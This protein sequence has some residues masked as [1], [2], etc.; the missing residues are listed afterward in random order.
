MEE[1]GLSCTNENARSMLSYNNKKQSMIGEIKYVTLVLCAHPKIHTTLN[2]QVIDM[3]VNN[4]SIILG[5][6]WQALTSGYFSLDGSHLSIPKDGKNVIVLREDRI[7][8]Y[9]EKVPQLNVNYI[10]EILGVYSIFI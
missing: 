4:Y 3:P 2:I 8:P 5:R 7:S 10:E 6:D 1:L 9:I